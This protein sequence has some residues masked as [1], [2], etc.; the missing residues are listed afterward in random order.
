M[1]GSLGHRQRF[2]V[3]MV[4]F[5]ITP[6][7]MYWLAIADTV[8]AAQECSQLQEQYDG[9]ADLDDQLADL[10]RQVATSNIALGMVPGKGRS[11]QTQ[12]LTTVSDYCKNS[13]LELVGIEKTVTYRDGDLDVETI[14][15]TVEG[16]FRETLRLIQYLETE[17]QTGR[18][19]SVNHRL[20]RIMQSRTN[21]LRTT[22]HVQNITKA[23]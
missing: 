16:G 19:I 18:L 6:F 1:M 13:K 3:L 8:S 4:L 14:P 10:R 22:I 12:L 20:E 5:G 7:I 9:I 21:V 2:R 15:I 11:F 17:A 23:S